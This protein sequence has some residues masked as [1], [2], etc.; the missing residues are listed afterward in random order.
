VSRDTWQIT[1]AERRQWVVDSAKAWLGTPWHHE[2]R[3]KGAG[4]DCANF[5]AAVYFESDMIPNLT[6]D[7]YPPDWHLHNA[8]PRF[9]DIVMKFCREVSAPL[10][11]DIVMFRLAR[12]AAHGAIFVDD[13]CTVI[14]HAW[15]EEG[16]VTLTDLPGSPWEK[17]VCGYYRWTG[18]A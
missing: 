15:K 16:R 3:V 11:G 9:L 14:A 2:A 12:A 5:L 13:E 17:R 8:E 1:E 10:V 4:V 7:H 6:L 18:F